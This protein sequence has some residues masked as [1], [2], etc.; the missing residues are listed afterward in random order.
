MDMTIGE[1]KMKKP[2][3][4]QKMVIRLTLV[5]IVILTLLAFVTFDYKDIQFLDAVILTAHTLK[6]MF[7]QPLLHHITGIFRGVR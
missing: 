2:F 3:N 5:S 6:T 1:L 4:K 7:F